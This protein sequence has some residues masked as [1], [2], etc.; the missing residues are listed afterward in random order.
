[1][2]TSKLI[3]KYFPYLFENNITLITLKKWTLTNIIGSNSKEYLQN[4]I[5]ID[6]NKLDSNHAICAHCN[7]NGKV[8]SNLRI[9]KFCENNYMYLQRKSTSNLQIQELKKYSIFSKI[10]IFNNINMLC[11][12]I[13]G[14]E[15][16]TELSK[17]FQNFPK[18]NS[19]VYRQDNIIL[20]KFDFPC[21]RFL[22]ISEKNNIILKKILQLTKKTNNDLWLTLDIASNI[23]IIE[24]E[25]SGKFLPQSLNLEKLKGLDFKKGCYYGQ[26]MISKAHYKNLNKYNLSWITT[27]SDTI[28]K[29]GEIIES[30][31][32]D[33]QWKNIGYVLATSQI[34]TKT[35][36]IQ[37][38]IKKNISNNDKI[39]IKNATNKKI[40]IKS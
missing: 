33:K 36:W 14:K 10:K 31:T 13:I 20:L 21:E 16:Q 34:N 7:I 22:L 27:K 17:Y 1:M 2:N 18:K 15:A 35:K 3:K 32:K 5:T 26:E 38:V 12:G 25:T 39:R 29:V 40:W 19:S 23:P 9:F 30:K 6:V 4:Q 8:W 11:L 24:K 28:I 37:A